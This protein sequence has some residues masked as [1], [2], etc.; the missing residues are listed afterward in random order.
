M[1]H[2]SHTDSSTHTV[3]TLEGRLAGEYVPLVSQFCLERL[4]NDRP[5][6]LFLKNVTEV[7]D[8]GH[9]LLRQLLVRG[10]RLRA[11]GIYTENL[12][13]D[14]KRE[15]EPGIQHTHGRE[16]LSKKTAHS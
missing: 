1:L 16:Q 4:T 2:V 6:V 8:S 7:D 9:D 10:V 11:A 13:E 5:L 15:C 3:I 14:L 12:V